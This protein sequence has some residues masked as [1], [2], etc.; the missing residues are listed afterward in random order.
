[1]HRDYDFADNIGYYVSIKPIEL[2]DG[3][4]ITYTIKSYST[5]KRNLEGSSNVIEIDEKGLASTIL[6][7]P[8]NKEPKV[9][10]QVAQCTKKDITIKI[11]D[12]YMKDQYVLNETIIESNKKN[13]FVMVNNILLETELSALGDKGTK[14]FI[15]HSGIMDRYVPK[16]IENPSIVFN[17]ETNEIILERPINSNDGCEYVVYV[18][19]DGE[20]SGKD[21]TL[22][23]IAEKEQIS[24]YSKSIIFYVNKSSITINFEK[25]GLKA[26]NRFEA[27]VYYEIKANTKM[28]FLSP[29]FTGF[30]GDVKI[31]VIT[32]IKQEYEQEKNIVFA[33]G[34]ATSK[35]GSLYF[36]YMP[37]ETR[38]VPVG[39]F[40]IEFNNEQEKSLIS[41]HCAYVNE[42]ETPRG[43]IEA[44]EDSKVVGDPYCIGG[45][46]VT[47]R[48]NYNYMFRYSYTNDKK[49]KRL[50]IK[51]ENNQNIDDGFNIYLRKGEN[52]YIEPTN[53]EEQREY[54]K[55]EENEKTI[56]PYII[57]LEKIRG[58][59]ENYISKILI[60]SRYLNMQ[61]YYIDETEKMRM[62]KL[63]FTGGIMLILTN[64][65]LAIKNIIQLN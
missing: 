22:C 58:K 19:K 59:E 11:V 25:I 5:N 7:S 56:M 61:M 40:R 65:D 2:T 37:E 49:P 15:R 1:M 13:Y 8:L 45:Q 3:I 12:A 27:I 53:F 62:P 38:D 10:I 41:V 34:K 29:I 54:G 26:Y 47:N 31:D 39:A 35:G 6:T 42:K 44:F 32:E 57:D 17:N 33:Q 55:S 24:S 21:I 18:G 52:T 51:V 48:K 30:V 4:D 63:L 9:F 64:P 36:S 16:I 14:V 43:M 46:S 50:I 60:Y 28:A 23:S 20:L